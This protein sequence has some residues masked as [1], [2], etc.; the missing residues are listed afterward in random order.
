MKDRRTMRRLSIKARIT[1]WY[2]ALIVLICASAIGFLFL[3]SRHAQTVYCRDTLQSA[4]VV[5]LDEM[6][7]E[8]G[9]I[10]IDADIDEVPNVYAALFDL[11]GN[12][13]YGRRRVEAPF[14][15]GSVRAVQSGGHSWM[16]LDERID[17]PEHE[18]IW[19]RLH[20]SADLPAG[21]SHT[22]LQVSLWMLPLLAVAALAGGYMMTRGALAPVKRMTLTAAEIAEGGDLSQRRRLEASGADGDELHALSATLEAMLARLEESFEREQRFTSDAAHELRTP[23]NAM[24][25]QAE[26]ALSRDDMGEKDEAIARMLDK[27]E[28][29]R[30]LVDQ[31]LLLAR[32]EA[33]RMPMEDEIDLA[34]MIESIVQDME[35]VAQE[36]NMRMQT[37]LQAISVRGNRAM[38]MRAVINLADNAIKYGRECGL[39]RMELV[40]EESHAVIRVTDDGEGLS[41]EAL[42][43]VFDRFWRGDSARATQG[44]GIGLSLVY[45]IAKAHGGSAQAQSMPG[46][47]C[48]FTIRI[49]QNFS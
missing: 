15:R 18:P 30:L 10:E 40:R 47:G 19:V 49:P 37:A 39:V 36:R 14:E 3:A 6:E 17:V 29:M 5:I 43:H 24:R 33:G 16:I 25:A 32:L 12:L 46:K 38:L 48:C 4:M 2:A 26:Y 45:M 44:T 35:P 13:V 1:L 23:I 11:K 22:V 21:I 27:N 34:Q 8:H 31:L 20:L 28:E 41:K 9:V 42:A 7:I